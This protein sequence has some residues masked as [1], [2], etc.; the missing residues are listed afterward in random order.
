MAWVQVVLRRVSLIGLL[1]ATFAFGAVAPME[2]AEPATFRDDADLLTG[3][4]RAHITQ[5]AQEAYLRVVVIT[6][7][8]RFPSR[9]AWQAWLREQAT[10][11]GAV[12]IGLHAVGGQQAIDVVPGAET[13]LSQSEAQQGVRRTLGTFNRDGVTAGIVQLIQ[14]Y[15]AMGATSPGEKAGE[16]LPWGWLLPV[17]GLALL[18]LLLWRLIAGRRWPAIG[19]AYG[20]YGSPSGPGGWGPGFGGG[21][22]SG[23]LGGLAGSWLG[24]QLVGHHNGGD[25]HAAGSNADASGPP[26]TATAASLE[27]G[28]TAGD[29]AGGWDSGSG[30][31]GNWGAP[32]S[33]GWGDTGGDSGGWT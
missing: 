7:A 28:W 16:G 23:V 19:G 33:G 22:L 10:D 27:G 24:S 11:R 20:S 12:T 5:A 1:L 21:F 18:V 14:K 13:G 6:S 4:G 26:D 31:T 30:D 15:R 25:A 8:E 17:A 32:D 9:S 3:G 29:D 2:A